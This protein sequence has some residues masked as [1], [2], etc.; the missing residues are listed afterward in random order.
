MSG[1]GLAYKDRVQETAAAPGTGTMT[2]AGA[3]VGFQAFSTAVVTGQTVYYEITDGTNWET[4]QG[5]Y[6]T[7]ST[8]LTRDVVFSSSNSGALV[9]FTSGVNVWLDLP[10]QTFADKA[11]TVAFVMHMVP[12]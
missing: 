4:G 1:P 5:I 3:V 11:L 8:T 10:A 6:T 9:N 2:L 7:A 12:Q